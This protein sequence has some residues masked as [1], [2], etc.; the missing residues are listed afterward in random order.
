MAQGRIIADSDVGNIGI[1]LADREYFRVYRE[2]PGTAFFLGAPV[3]SR[4]IGTWLISAAYPLRDHDGRLL[5]V[6]AAA[7]EPPYFEKLWGAIDLEA[8][9]AID[10]YRRDG[11]LM[12]SSSARNPAIGTPAADPAILAAVRAGVDSVEA[13]L[14]ARAGAQDRLIIGKVLTPYPQLT[15]V[16]NRSTREML[17][18][19][20]RFSL[21]ILATW[22]AACAFVAMLYAVLRK[23]WSQRY[24]AVEALS[25]SEQKFSAA[26][27][28]SPDA[29]LITRASDGHFVEIS[30][31]VP[32]I[33]GYSR[34]DLIGRSSLELNIWCDPEDRHRY[35]TEMKANG[36]VANMEAAFR[37]RSG[38]VRIGQMSGELID[39]AGQA[40]VLG[41]IRD[42]TDI[43]RSE[44]LIWKQAHFDAL[45]GLPN[46]TMFVERLRG[47]IDATQSQRRD[48]HAA[49]DR[50]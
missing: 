6:L 36:R 29:I 26:F 41:I 31:S 19:W 24:D 15:L 47:Q 5:G 49:D 37:I 18:P 23:T 17:A 33:T 3:R 10:L 4:S 40:H 34:E 7:L 1:S 27:R 50:P 22:L 12:A 25:V 11:I 32:R 43:K 46:R 48:L 16:A 9:G 39:V 8:H 20:R 28:A 14:F 38:E 44:E 35:L 2:H 30:D 42:I 21:L 13:P 45:T